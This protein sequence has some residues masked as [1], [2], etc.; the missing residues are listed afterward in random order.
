MTDSSSTSTLLWT[1]ATVLCAC[2]ATVYLFFRHKFNYWAARGV[3]TVQPLIPV[4]NLKNFGKTGHSS[5]VVREFYQQL[6]GRG[7]TIGGLYFFTEPVLLLL[8]LEAVK[9]VLIK[10]FHNFPERGIYY[11]EKDDPLSA[12]MFALDGPAWRRVRSKLTPTFTSGKMKFMF[13][14]VVDVA[15]RFQL[16]LSELIA[17]PGADRVL[18]MRELLARFTTDVIG[19]CAFGIECNSLKDP[20]AKFRE[21]GR[22]VFA[23]PRNRG[24]KSFL[25]LSFRHVARRLRMKVQRD[26]VSEFFM[27]IVR[28]TIE[29][30]EKGGVRRNDFMDLLIELKNE[31]PKDGGAPLSVEE[32]AAQAFVFFLAGFET[33]STT[34]SYALYELSLNVEI[35]QRARDEVKS[36]L[37]R[38]GG[39]MTYEAMMEMHYVEQILNGKSSTTTHPD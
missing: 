23:E 27:D 35:Q 38:H 10:D 20:N 36:V 8:E 31:Q 19:T 9:A 5:Q 29:Y 22:K 3:P 25:I 18:E 26:D 17:A 34:L 7:S 13:T 1:V 15:E 37:A 6:R 33:S 4:G 24:L 28:Q 39:E 16:C 11:N 21:M 14:T 32:V 30:R 12:H 2:A